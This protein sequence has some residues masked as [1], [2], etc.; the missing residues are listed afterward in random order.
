MWR[1]ALCD[2]AQNY[3]EQLSAIIEQWRRKKHINVQL[4]SFW[5]TE[6]VLGDMEDNGD[7][8]L[9]FLA[10]DLKGPGV[11]ETA[12]QIRQK[13]RYTSIIFV[14]QHQQYC[15]QIL[16]FG[17][18]HYLEK[19]ISQQ[20]VF[21][22]LDKVLEESHYLYESFTFRFDRRTYMI[23]LRDVLYFASEKRVIKIYMRDEKEYV[24]Y[25]KLDRLEQSLSCYFTTFLRIHKSYL[26]NTGHIEQF[27]MEEIMIRNGD[28]LPISRERRNI[29]ETFQINSLVIG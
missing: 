2:N 4:E 21:G 1:I 23:P 8:S 11:M 17:S 13:N 14:S 22:V 15:K 10:T 29:I 25:E 18:C 6:E 28:L 9:I 7:F 3:V 24:F 26:V 19:P 5:S 12:R 20:S 16:E 27:R